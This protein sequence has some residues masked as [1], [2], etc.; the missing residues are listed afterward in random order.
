MKFTNFQRNPIK[1][2]NEA[3]QSVGF[4]SLARTL[5]YFMYLLSYLSVIDSV[6]PLA[7]QARIRCSLFFPLQCCIC[8]SIVPVEPVL[9]DSIAH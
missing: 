8:A 5:C 4:S 1:K 3:K 2:V 9:K 6:W 7:L